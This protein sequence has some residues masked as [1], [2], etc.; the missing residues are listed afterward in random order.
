MKA[1]KENSY[2]E[3]EQRTTDFAKRIIRLCKELPKDRINNRLVDQIIR[4]SG[5]VGANYRETNEALGKKDFS[6]RLR[7]ARKESKETQ[8]WL[9]LIEEA[10]PKMSARMRNL[11]QEI[12]EIRNILSAIIVKANNQKEV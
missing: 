11:F 7:I 5:S 4:S 9:E 2:R 6:F 12:I 10:N 3:F 8:H 1:Q